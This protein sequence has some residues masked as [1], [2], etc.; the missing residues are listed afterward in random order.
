ML[1]AALLL[2]LVSC[3]ADSWGVK[4]SDVPPEATLAFPGSDLLTRG[5]NPGDKGTFIDGGSADYA[6]R[7]TMDYE[8]A[9]TNPE[10]I[11]KWYNEQLGELGYSLQPDIPEAIRYRMLLTGSRSVDGFAVDF[12]ISGG[13]DVDGKVT[14]FTVTVVV[15]PN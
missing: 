12:G 14:G 10:E 6:P 11:L 9:P 5:W 4:E 3:G 8:L 15:K 1:G 2:L 7:L 13:V